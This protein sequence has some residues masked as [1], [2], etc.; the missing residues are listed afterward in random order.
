V[1]TIPVARAAVVVDV[2]TMVL[3]ANVVVA[4]SGNDRHS[5]QAC[6]GVRSKNKKKSKP[7]GRGM[8]NHSAK[9]KIP[10]RK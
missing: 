8:R 3:G 9:N 1:V 7:Q 10:R 2:A 6:Q 4:A 5:K